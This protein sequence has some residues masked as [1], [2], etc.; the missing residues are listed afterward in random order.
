MLMCRS[1]G[2][3]FVKTKKTAGTSVEAYLEVVCAPQRWTGDWEDFHVTGGILDDD[4]VV[5]PRGDGTRRR[6]DRQAMVING[7]RLVNHMPPSRIVTAFGRDLWDSSV[8][9]AGVRNPWDRMASMFFWS[10][11]RDASRER[12]REDANLARSGF[13]DFLRGWEREP[14][15]VEVMGEE[16]GV[17]EYLRYEH[18]DEDLSRLLARVG[19]ADPGIPM[20]RLKSGGRPEGYAW[21]YD[22]ES[23]QKVQA[24]YADVI[25]RFGYTFES[26]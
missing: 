12:F 21:L 8:T 19:L 4:L 7:V 10:K 26:G 22:T 3:I 24:M 25:D 16:F 6:A 9:S 11:R 1:A 18:L 15:D 23:R 5:T 20:P 17:D 14:I 13:A 2:L